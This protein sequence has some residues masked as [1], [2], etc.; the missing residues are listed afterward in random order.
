M[1]K[2]AHPRPTPPPDNRL[3]GKTSNGQPGRRPL[4]TSVALGKVPSPIG[5]LTAMVTPHGLVALAFDS[6]HEHVLHK[7]LAAVGITD[8]AEDR[9][10]MAESLAWMSAY[11]DGRSAEP[12]RLDRRLMTPFQSQVLDTASR[13]PVGEVRTYGEV[14]AMVGKPRAAR[15]VGRALA[16]N[17]LPIVLP[18]HRVIARDGTL[19]G[20]A[21]GLGHKQVL[22]D[23]E[24]RMAS[25]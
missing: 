16:T 11:R 20:Y 25:N 10:Q 3:E 1:I 21:G 14:A 6:D 18:C 2:V 13:I 15:A 17:P 24:R 19:N 7:K 23:H 12:P 22:L 4:A 9:G 8:T 5:S